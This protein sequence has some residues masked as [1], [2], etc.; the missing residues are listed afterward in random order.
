MTCQCGDKLSRQVFAILSPFLALFKDISPNL[1]CS[2]LHPEHSELHLLQKIAKFNGFH[3]LLHATDDLSLI[4]RRRS[5]PS[6]SAEAGKAFAAW[7]ASLPELAVAFATT[8]ARTP[9]EAF[10]TS[11][12]NRAILAIATVVARLAGVSSQPIP[13]AGPRAAG[14][15]LQAGI[16]C[17]AFGP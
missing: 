1:P 17:S 5:A 15:T 7:S 3:V 8:M 9:L 12:A 4:S 6:C 14:I 10:V 2:A 13:A 11:R 16:A